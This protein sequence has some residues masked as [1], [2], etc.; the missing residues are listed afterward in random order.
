MDST[1]F[2]T[3]LT[4]IQAESPGRC[5]AVGERPQQLVGIAEQR[6]GVSFPSEYQAFLRVF[7]TFSYGSLEYYGL[8]D[9]DFDNSSIPDVV[10]FNESIR[11]EE[12]F[13]HDLIA[14]SDRDGVIYICLATADTAQTQRGHVIIWDNVR[15]RISNDTGID[16]ATFILEEIEQMQ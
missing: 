10:W 7:G 6:L 1:H 8:I 11:R 12:D 13:P 2:I 4:R 16:F 15:K 14:I 9:D 5:F 3:Q